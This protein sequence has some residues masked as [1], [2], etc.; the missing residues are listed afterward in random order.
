MLHDRQDNGDGNKYLALPYT[1]T[2]R[3]NHFK[4]VTTRTKNAN[5]A[6]ILLPF[7]VNLLCIYQPDWWMA[8]CFINGTNYCLILGKEWL[9]HVDILEIFTLSFVVRTWKMSNKHFS[10]FTPKKGIF[11]VEELWSPSRVKLEIKTNSWAHKLYW[12][13]KKMKVLCG[14]NSRKGSCGWK[15]FYRI[16]LHIAFSTS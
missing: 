6:H 4:H 12:G 5:S 2:F 9:L 16:I 15:P 7:G 1:C 10:K 13:V 8:A 14:L 11:F 3:R